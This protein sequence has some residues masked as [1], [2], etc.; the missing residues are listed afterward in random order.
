M[1]PTPRIDV[2]AQAVWNGGLAFNLFHAFY[3]RQLKP[4]QRTSYQHVARSMASELYHLTPQP[5]ARPP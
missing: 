2:A 4:E 1:S 5:Q 3:R